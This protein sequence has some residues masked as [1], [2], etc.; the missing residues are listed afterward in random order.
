MMTRNFENRIFQ[1]FVVKDNEL[2][3]SPVKF[4]YL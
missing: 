2:Q 3:L 4:S 1:S